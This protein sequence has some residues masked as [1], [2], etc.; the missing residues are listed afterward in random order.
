MRKKGSRHQYVQGIIQKKYGCI[1][2]RQSQ[3]QLKLGVWEGGGAVNP[4][5]G[6]GQCL[7]ECVGDNPQNNF[8]FFCKKHDR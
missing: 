7:G 4:P 2:S 3:K 1:S 8:A 5:W 6:P